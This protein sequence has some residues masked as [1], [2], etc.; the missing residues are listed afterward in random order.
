MNYRIGAKELKETLKAWDQTL[1]GRGKI[2]LIACGGTALTLLGHK[3]STKDVDFLVPEKKEYIR[4]TQF[5]KQAGYAQITSYGWKRP[6]ESI[7]FDLYAGNR[8]YSTELFDSPLKKGGNK[9][10]QEWDKIYLGTLNG[11]DLIISKMFRGDEID[12]E[13]S[14]LLLQNEKMDLEKLKKRF[15]ET[16]QYEVN[17]E[18]MLGN[19]DRLLARMKK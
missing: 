16:A 6:E 12:I 3:E 9:K 4:L 19:L 8:V 11:Y 7:I 10:I 18:K 15:K 2:H 1:P 13:D 17:E 5:L 14:L